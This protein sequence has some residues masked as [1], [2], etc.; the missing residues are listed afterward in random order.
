MVTVLQTRTYSFGFSAA[1]IF[2][3]SVI[4]A[5]QLMLKHTYILIAP[6]VER[7]NSGQRVFNQNSVIHVVLHAIN[8][9]DMINSRIDLMSY[10]F[11]AFFA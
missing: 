8:I 4:L 10:F 11:I 6:L 7:W 9:T 1:E 2:S 3:K 5:L